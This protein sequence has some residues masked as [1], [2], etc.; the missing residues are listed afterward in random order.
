MPPYLYH[1]VFQRW[2]KNAFNLLV[3]PSERVVR[4][5]AELM[6][7]AT[8]LYESEAQRATA[9]SGPLQRL[10]GQHIEIVVNTDRT[11][12]D[13]RITFPLE[14]GSKVSDI[15]IRSRHVYVTFP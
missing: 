6:R 3:K 7:K 11:V 4:A 2:K 13:G 1:P 14:R 12:P 5:A 8:I 9:L 10:L 15:D